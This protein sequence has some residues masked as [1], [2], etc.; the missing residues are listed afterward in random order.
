MARKEYIFKG[1]GAEGIAADVF[2]E[3][4]DS[5]TEFPIGSWAFWIFLLAMV[6]VCSANNSVIQ[7]C[8]T[9]V[10]TLLSAQRSFYL[11]TMSRNFS[12]WASLSFR[13]T[14]DSAPRFP[15]SEAQ[16]QMPWM[17]IAGPRMSYHVFC[18]Q[19]LVFA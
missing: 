12:T 4:G 18:T 7:H 16:S 5:A 10:V 11:K 19:T 6:C 13:Q 14:I 17:H 3:E 8:T 2:Y 9:T 1:Q 15:S